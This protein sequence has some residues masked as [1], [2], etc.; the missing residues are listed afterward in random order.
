MCFAISLVERVTSLSLTSQLVHVTSKLVCIDTFIERHVR[1]DSIIWKTCEHLTLDIACS[2]TNS[3]T[4]DHTAHCHTRVAGWHSLWMPR[5]RNDLY[6]VG[7]G[8]KLY[9]LT[10]CGCSVGYNTELPK[11]RQRHTYIAPQAAHRSCSG[12]FVSQT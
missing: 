2:R 6:C 4:W 3:F 8:V 12:S 11:R 9:S 1:G 10:P 5:L 7:W